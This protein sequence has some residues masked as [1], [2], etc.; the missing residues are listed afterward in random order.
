MAFFMKRQE[1]DATPE[2][3]WTHFNKIHDDRSPELT[4][5]GYIPIVQAPALELDTLYTVDL[6][7][8]YIARKL[9]QHHVVL[10][11]DDTLY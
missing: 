10:T 9:G 6:R 3:G 8:K 4:S 7:C 5:V 11:V 1:N 2:K